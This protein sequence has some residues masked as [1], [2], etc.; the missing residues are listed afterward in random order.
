MLQL[1][2]LLQGFFVTLYR[3]VGRLFLLGSSDRSLAEGLGIAEAALS[4]EPVIVELSNDILDLILII[5][6]QQG[7]H[8]LVIRY[9]S[10]LNPLNV[11]VE[12]LGFHGA[13]RRLL[14][15]QGELPF[16]ELCLFWNALVFVVVGLGEILTPLRDC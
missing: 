16:L 3:F 1:L 4:I 8:L 14:L 5:F 7:P 13:A 11:D 9:R 10:L 2:S 6:R 15:A 12:V